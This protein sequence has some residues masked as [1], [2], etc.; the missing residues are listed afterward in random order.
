MS[1]WLF[2]PPE[3][4]VPMEWWQWVICVLLLVGGAILA[5]LLAHTPIA[6][7]FP[8]PFGVAVTAVL[9]FEVFKI[10]RAIPAGDKFYLIVFLVLYAGLAAI[11]LCVP[12]II[13]SFTG[14]EVYYQYGESR[15]SVPLLAGFFA[16][17]ALGFF[18]DY[19]AEY[20]GS[21]PMSLAGAAFIALIVF[22]ILSDS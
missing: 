14:R 13:A 15:N 6:S 4:V 11:S 10:L 22:A 17:G 8:I 9:F 3:L 19:V 21:I 16:A 18:A 7:K 1:D 2:E 12:R 20:L 5:G